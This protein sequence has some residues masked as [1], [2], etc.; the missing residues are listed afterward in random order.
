MIRRF[1]IMSVQWTSCSVQK[2]KDI[3]RILNPKAWQPPLL[4]VGG[5]AG[6]LGRALLK[7]QGEHFKGRTTPEFTDDLLEIEEVLRAAREIYREDTD[8]CGINTI[9]GD[10]R[11]YTSSKK[12]GLIVLSNFLHAYSPVE[13]EKL[14]HK[15][16]SLLSSGG[17]ILI[18]DYFPDRW[19]STPS[20]A[21]L[22][23]LAM[24]LKHI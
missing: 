12:Y 13:A 9:K 8:W 2:A 24:M 16:V 15:A 22:Y 10:F 21:P 14:L 3:V 23:D 20:K 11:H 17:M 4:D 18:H 1:L 7:S 6:S 5:G 19:G